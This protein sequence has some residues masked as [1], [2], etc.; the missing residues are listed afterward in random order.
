MPRTNEFGQ[1]VGDMVDFGR[2]ELAS[3]LYT[4]AVV[5]YVGAHRPTEYDYWGDARTSYRTSPHHAGH[6][7]RT[8]YPVL[9]TLGVDYVQF[10][11]EA[12]DAVAELEPVEDCHSTFGEGSR[13]WQRDMYA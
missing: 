12:T 11:T 8:E 9:T 4:A 2:N 7:L 3:K 6:D 13:W 10:A 1:K 5:A